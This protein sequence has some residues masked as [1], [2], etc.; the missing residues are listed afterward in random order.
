MAYTTYSSIA[1][2]V[3]QMQAN[4]GPVFPVP[5]P[6]LILP[7]FANDMYEDSRWNRFELGGSLDVQDEGK[8]LDTTLDL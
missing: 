1:G 5:L 7:N 3:S 6:S 4:D 8:C 2:I